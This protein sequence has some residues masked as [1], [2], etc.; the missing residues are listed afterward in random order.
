MT[1]LSLGDLGASASASASSAGWL[2]GRLYGHMAADVDKLLVE[3]CC[4][5]LLWPRLKEPMR[6]KF[7]RRERDCW[8]PPRGPPR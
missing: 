6:W 1:T 8:S 2:S 4:S 3:L 7:H 5:S